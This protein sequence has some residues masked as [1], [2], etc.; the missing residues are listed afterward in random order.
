MLTAMKSFKMD[1]SLH[2]LMLVGL[3]SVLLSAALLVL[4]FLAL[5]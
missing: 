2:D 5:T 3:F 1:G 4:N